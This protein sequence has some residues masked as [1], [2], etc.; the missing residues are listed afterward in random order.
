MT[1]Q[2]EPQKPAQET[3][4]DL[5]IESLPVAKLRPVTNN[6][7][8]MPF[9]VSIVS[10]SLVTVICFLN[11]LFAAL[12]LGE[13]AFV[14]ALVNVAYGLLVLWVFGATLLGAPMVFLA[15]KQLE[16][17]NFFVAEKYLGRYLDLVK[18]MHLYQDGYYTVAVA[19]LAL[20]KLARG[21]YHHAELLYEELIGQVKKRKRLAKHN[22][23][24]VYINNL[25]HVKIAQ[26]C[27]HEELFDLEL[28]EAERLAKE[29]LTIWQGAGAQKNEPAGVA[30]PL[31][32]LAEI[33]ILRGDLSAAESKLSQVIKLNCDGRQSYFILPES[34]QG[35][36]FESHLWL[37][38]LYLQ[39]GKKEEA[40]LLSRRLI[41]ELRERPAPIL[42]HSMSVLN[43]L[44]QKYMDLGAWAEAEYVLEFAYSVARGYPMHPEAHEIAVSFERLLTETG[45]KGEIADM[46]LWIRPVLEL[47]LDAP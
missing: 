8:S 10:W 15:I 42:Q 27:T 7:L 21:D 44:G 19:N 35:L 34:R 16:K 41:G 29:A 5:V 30:Y 3:A 24:A 33:D 37:A 47:G 46:K 43:R 39:Q 40:D 17:R 6:W 11:F 32:V 13:G 45:R 14:P 28:Q 2:N 4:K 18:A 23:T 38:L 12:L 36:Y 20:I 26:A 1:E 9:A 25:A 22:I 31:Q